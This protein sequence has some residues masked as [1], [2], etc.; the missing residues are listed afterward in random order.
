MN[1]IKKYISKIPGKRLPVVLIV[2]L[3]FACTK[4]DKSVCYICTTTYIVTTDQT[5][6]GYPASTTVDF[7]LCDITAEQAAD[8][9]QTNKGSE[10]DVVGGVTYS[11]S[12]STK[13]RQE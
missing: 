1:S 8:F 13:C 12:H 6:P 11:S 10:S 2:L 9:E 3:A 4:E 7:E 5:V